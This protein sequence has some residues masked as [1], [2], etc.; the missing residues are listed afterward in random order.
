MARVSL[1]DLLLI[2]A[3]G[4]AT[5]LGI[6]KVYFLTRKQLPSETPANGPGGSPMPSQPALMHGLSISPGKRY[7]AQVEVNFPASVAAS[8]D[9]VREYAAKEGFVNVQVFEKKPADFPGADLAADYYVRA[10]YQG[11]P[12]TLEKSYGGGQVNIL[13]AWEG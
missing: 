5:Y 6:Q 3:G 4:I 8:V 7:H 1:G 12:R 2:G 11:A 13:G 10:I 9:K